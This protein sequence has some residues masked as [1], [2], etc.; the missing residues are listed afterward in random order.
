MILD[1]SQTETPADH[2]NRERDRAARAVAEAVFVVGRSFK[3]CPAP[4]ATAL[5][6]A[7]NYLLRRAADYDPTPPEVCPDCHDSDLVHRIAWIDART[8]EFAEW[9]DPEDGSDLDRPYYCG[10]CF[11]IVD[12][13]GG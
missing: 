3:E 5:R 7:A 10:R 12:P 13:E 8:L 11:H 6:S 1:A 2:M 9:T 4:A